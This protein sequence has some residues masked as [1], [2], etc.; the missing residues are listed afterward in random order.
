MARSDTEEQN[1][2]SVTYRSRT[3]GQDTDENAEDRAINTA[4]SGHYMVSNLDEEEE[5]GDDKAK[6]VE[7]I[8]GYNFTDAAK[9]TQQNYQFGDAKNSDSDKIDSSLTKL[10][11]CMT[12]AYR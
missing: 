9:D 6:I 1:N 4:I 10:F 11:E 8:K 3:M 2:A 12:L 7:E 5:D